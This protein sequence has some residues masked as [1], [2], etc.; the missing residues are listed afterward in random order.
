MT[1]EVAIL[2]AYAF[3][4]QGKYAEAVQTLASVPEAL[5]TP[6]GADLI[7]RIRFEQ[8]HETAARRIWEAILAVDPANEPA[9]KALSALDAQ[10]EA[11]EKV[12]REPCL[13]RRRKYV[14][15]A[16]LAALLGIAFSVGKAWRGTPQRN[17]GEVRAEAELRPR[18]I[19][20]QTLEIS[21]INGKVLGELREGLLTNLTDSTVLVLSGG[22][23]RYAAERAKSL[24]V[25]V[26]S[27]S[28]VAGVPASSILF[29]VGDTSSSN[30][31]FSVVSRFHGK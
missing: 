12:E 30:V 13:G 23:G 3:A 17:G 14:R 26:D 4:S 21:K 8:G 24:S 31:S 22:R 28:A 25:I 6:A 20:G 19:A 5:N 10:P 9:R 11:P 16:V 7:A 18:I 2:R 29:Q 1:A 15:A 27:L